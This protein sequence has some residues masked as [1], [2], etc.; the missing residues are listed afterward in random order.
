MIKKIA[1]AT[2]LAGAFIGH[3]TASS[4]CPLGKTV[5]HRCAYAISMARAQM[6]LNGQ[7]L[8]EMP[9][10]L[11]VNLFAAVVPLY[12]PAAKASFD[13]E[14]RSGKYVLTMPTGYEDYVR[15]GLDWF[16]MSASGASYGWSR[17]LPSNGASFVIRLDKKGPFGGDSWLGAFLIMV[18][19]HPQYPYDASEVATLIVNIA[20]STMLEKARLTPPAAE[21]PLLPSR[22]VPARYN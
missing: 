8:L 4:T 7:G 15:A 16:D 22:D 14:G 18:G 9:A 11:I 3:A 17:P 2:I 10:Y 13:S 6:T 12:G 20:K 21:R 1:V 5:E 19:R